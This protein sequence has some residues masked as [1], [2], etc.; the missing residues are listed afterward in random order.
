MFSEDMSGSTQHHI[1]DVSYETLLHYRIAC[2]MTRTNRPKLRRE[3]RGQ[4]ALNGSA[5]ARALARVPAR[6]TE[7]C[8]ARPLSA[9]ELYHFW[10]QFSKYYSP[11]CPRLTPV[12]TFVANVS[13]AKC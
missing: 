3:A 12:S 9:V 13:A 8:G 6:T 5:C 4:R 10:V 2:S 7:M 11:L 1:S